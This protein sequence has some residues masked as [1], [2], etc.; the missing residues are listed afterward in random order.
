MEFT[1]CQ[2][3]GDTVNERMEGRGTYK[4]DNGTEYK[5]QIKDGMFHGRGTLHFQNGSQ[6]QGIWEMGRLVEQRFQFDDGLEYQEN[7]KNWPYC[8]DD[9]GEKSDRRFYHEIVQSGSNSEVPSNEKQS[10]FASLSS[11][12][13]KPAYP[14]GKQSEHLPSNIS[15]QK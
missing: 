2:Y 9:N 8:R 14:H 5:G 1:R 7:V 10:K 15:S 3:V 4:F 13:V 12:G 6:L 11:S